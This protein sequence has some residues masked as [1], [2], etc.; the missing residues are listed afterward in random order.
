MSFTVIG[1]II[2]LVSGAIALA[3]IVYKW[4]MNPNRIRTVEENDRL[5]QKEK[6]DE[7]VDNKRIKDI[8]DIL[9]KAKE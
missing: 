9:R 3:V 2:S 7:A 5:D 1:T 8:N 4:R 6:I